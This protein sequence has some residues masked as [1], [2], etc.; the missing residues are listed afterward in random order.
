MSDKEK[1]VSVSWSHENPEENFISHRLHSGRNQGSK[2]RGVQCISSLGLLRFCDKDRGE[3]KE[4]GGG[5]SHRRSVP[6]A[7]LSQT[8]I[9]EAAVQTGCGFP[10]R[11]WCPKLINAFP[12]VSIKGEAVTLAG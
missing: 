6:G 12:H 9:S 10:L 2:A 7:P 5:A 3:R 1:H 8:Q 11:S 4:R